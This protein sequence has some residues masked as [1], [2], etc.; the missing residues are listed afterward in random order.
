MSPPS[1]Y[2]DPTPR[3]LGFAQFTHI[4]LGGTPPPVSVKYC[5]I[6]WNIRRE[7]GPANA[8]SEAQ[9]YYDAVIYTVD[10]GGGGRYYEGTN[11]LKIF[12]PGTYQDFGC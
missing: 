11:N 1:L 3:L 2:F 6:C 8:E 4:C 5:F 7:T 9:K 10:P 12:W